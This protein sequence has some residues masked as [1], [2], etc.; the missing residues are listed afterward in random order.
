MTFYIKIPS[1][2]KEGEY[3]EYSY[4]TVKEM[5]IDL[6]ISEN[7]VYAIFNGKCAFNRPCTIK[8]KDCI[9]YKSQTNP[10][11]IPINKDILKLS[12]KIEF[13]KTKDSE[14]NKI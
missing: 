3:N 1:V 11:K 2:E 7:T 9:F 13:D 14:I 10:N 12:Q 6:G 4:S 8:L 5:A